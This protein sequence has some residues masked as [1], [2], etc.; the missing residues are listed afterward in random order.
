MEKCSV[1]SNHTR[2]RNEKR[3]RH[4]LLT[5]KGLCLLGI[6]GCGPSGTS[7]SGKVSFQGQPLMSG[8]VMFQPADGMLL[9]SPIAP[10][11][12]Y[13]IVGAAPGVVAIAVTGPAKTVVG[14]D[15]VSA[16]DPSSSGPQVFIPEKYG[17]LE[18]AGL[19]YE[20]TDAGT[21]VHDI[22]LP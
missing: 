6:V 13:R 18:T 11:G 3:M 1:I 22:D 5:I 2:K 7:V 14:P 20:V 17:L 16:D 10:D 4:F 19:T 15:G 12:M 9:Q 21:Q 8:F